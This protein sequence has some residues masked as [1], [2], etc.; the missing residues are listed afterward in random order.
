MAFGRFV[1]VSG[2][3]S[4]QDTIRGIHTDV[5]IVHRHRKDL[6]EN[7]LDGF[8][9]V[10]CHLAVA[11]N[12]IVVAADIRLANVL[13]LH[14]ADLIP[15]KPIVHI[16][17]I[18]KSMLFQAHFVLTPQFKEV[19]QG[20]IALRH[21]DALCQVMLD[22]FFLFPQPLQGCIIDGMAFSVFSSP[23]VHI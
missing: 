17:V 19:V 12:A 3:Y 13:E 6:M 14:H 9:R 4:R 21:T 11:D 15:N 22:F 18:G 2:F 1:L 5:L 16:N 8:Q 7:I 20:Q 23:T 10:Q